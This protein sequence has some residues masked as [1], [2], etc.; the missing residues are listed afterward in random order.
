M[1]KKVLVSSNGSYVDVRS[2]ETGLLLEI[3]S[4]IRQRAEDGV[5][6]QFADSVQTIT[7]YGE[8]AK[9]VLDYESYNNELI[10]RENEAE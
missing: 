10:R 9:V 6:I 8:K 1:S 7:V 3:V 4:Y 2:M 5:L